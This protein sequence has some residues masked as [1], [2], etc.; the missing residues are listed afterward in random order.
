MQGTEL[1]SASFFSCGFITAI[2]VNSPEKKLAN[3]PLCSGPWFIILYVCHYNPQ[4]VYFK[5]IFYCRLYCKTASVTDKLCQLY[6][7]VLT[8][9]WNSKRDNNIGKQFVNLAIVI[10]SCHGVMI[11]II[12]SNKKS[13]LKILTHTYLRYKK[14]DNWQMCMT[15][16]LLILYHRGF[17][18]PSKY[19]GEEVLLSFKY[20]MQEGEKIWV[21]KVIWWA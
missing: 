14:Y 20:S 6:T 12:L 16:Q 5:S 19:H 13:R 15:L 21:P 7:D 1:R 17:S 10:N 2:V 11:W 9:F 3:A 18:T 4:F 8:K